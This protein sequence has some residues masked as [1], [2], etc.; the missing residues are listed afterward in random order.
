MPKIYCEADGEL[1]GSIPLSSGMISGAG[2]VG[3]SVG[4]GVPFEANSPVSSGII[5]GADV[6]VVTGGVDS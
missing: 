5:S 6:L 3:A 2:L 4:L 1:G